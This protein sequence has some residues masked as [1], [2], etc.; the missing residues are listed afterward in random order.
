MILCDSAPLSQRGQG[1]E[2]V[3][4]NIIRIFVGGK[5]HTRT[6]RTQIFFVVAVVAA[7]HPTRPDRS[8]TRDDAPLKSL[9][10]P[11]PAHCAVLLTT[12]CHPPPPRPPCSHHRLATATVV[13][14]V[15]AAHP[16]E[17]H[18]VPP[19]LLRSPSPPY[20]LAS[21]AIGAPLPHASRFL[22][23][24]LHCSC[25]QQQ[26]HQKRQQLHQPSMMSVTFPKSA[27][28]CSR[29][30]PTPLTFTLE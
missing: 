29:L 17:S 16:S 1:C 20:C 28:Q 2:K 19:A 13:A 5:V 18:H 30:S 14:T 3:G 9:P 7:R 22:L 10:A 8:T 24:S 27:L 21:C 23:I 25:T 12:S 6:R 4:L 26:Q 15:F 11:P